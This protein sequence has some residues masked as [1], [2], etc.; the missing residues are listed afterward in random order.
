MTPLRG[1]A[2]LTAVPAAV[3]AASPA[4]AD[5]AARRASVALRF[6]PDGCFQLQAHERRLLVDGRPAALGARAFDLLLALAYRP[7]QL[8][9][10]NALMDLVWPGVVVEENNLAA[11][12]SALR[13]VLGGALIATVPGR[14]YCFTGRT[15][16]LV[17]GAVGAATGAAPGAALGAQAATSAP[18]AGS[19]DP[20][21]D[22]TAGAVQA[23]AHATQRTNLPDQ[24]APLIGRDADLAALGVLVQSHRLVT[25]VGAGGIGKTRLAQTFLQAQRRAWQ[26]G[27]CWVE[28]AAVTDP[29]AVPEAIT[30]ALDVRPGSG[31]PLATL[32][33]AV[34][35]LQLLVVLDNAEHQLVA[36]ARVAQ[37]L[38]DAAPGLRLV[39]TSQAPLA[40]ATERV[41]RLDTLAVPPGPLPA[42]QALR[43][44]AIE[45][46]T[47]RAQALDR[48]FVLTDTNAPTVIELCAALDGLALAIEL[49]AARV[50]LMGVPR[51]LASMQD[52]LRLLT[53][54]L[55]RLA[56]ARQ[57]TLRATLEWSH[58][59]LDLPER[60]VF[61]RLGV[62]AGSAS[63]SLVQQVVADP[64]MADQPAAD[65]P[66][67]GSLDEWAVIDALGV[68]VERSLVTVLGA[69]DGDGPRY[70]LLE[71]SRLFAR[72]RLHTAGEHAALCSRHAQALA[73]QF[74][75]QW[76]ERSSGR[77]GIRAWDRQIGQDAANAREAIAWVAQAAQA[78]Q[79]A[80]VDQPQPT[81]WALTIAATW[82][83]AIPRSLHTERMALAD[84][85]EAVNTP[86]LPACLRQRVAL[87][88]ARTWTNSRKHRGLA[89]AE[90][91]LRLARAQDANE[92]DRWLLYQSLNQWVEV[93][94]GLSDTDPATLVAAMAEARA[95]EDPD[96]PPIRLLAGLN[97]LMLFLSRQN[98][99]DSVAAE[100]LSAAQRIAVIARAAGD[101][102]TAQWGNL[103]DAQLRA[104]DAAAAI[105]TGQALLAQLEG[106][107]DETPLAYARLNLAAALLALDDTAQAGPVLRDGWRQALA[108][109]L[110]PYYADYLVLLAAL[111]GRPRAAAR[112]AGYADAANRATGAK[113]EDNEAAAIERA[114]T[115]A[116]A[117]LG[118]A[119]FDRLHTQGQ[120]LRDPQ[121]A[122]LAFGAIDE[123][124][125]G[126]AEPI[127]A[128]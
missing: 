8:L 25:L 107:R 66:S 44:G 109:D 119:V 14:G 122:A 40:L 50:H 117:A 20:D 105:R 128:L 3:S 95:L 91:A 58:D 102:P 82:L 112:L 97:A 80:Q 38:L 104:G 7:G 113:R 64:P 18:A 9:T 73:G 45:L 12:I 83:M 115:L 77:I 114:R 98:T 92:P 56:P 118:E 34:A 10:K 33:A 52:R 6:G 94:S 106:S 54:N 124:A 46:F 11:Q 79:T 76:R 32:C 61:R 125:D 74:D 27:V 63:L 68:L 93:G 26:H 120:T 65:W 28:L 17:A 84:T 108:F 69:D 37:A 70:R 100:Y 23:P 101:D 24:L 22:A 21:A 89:A 121:I 13:K 19:A 16:A 110:Q 43:F 5:G 103:M 90:L 126:E 57:Q 59:L 86:M 1:P 39:I 71:S 99:N 4:D 60:T 67:A 30:T 116:R 15:E 29:L 62:I 2:V 75:L 42:A 31:E 127:Q 55:N 36:V 41:V 111:V 51:L 35:P 72:E 81:Q 123:A 53:R 48:N 96:W 88:L 47:E 78:A 87:V 49:A 85:C